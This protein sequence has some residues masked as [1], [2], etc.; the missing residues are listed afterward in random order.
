MGLKS[1][2]ALWMQRAID[3]MA[4]KGWA[5]LALMFFAAVFAGLIE[6][7]YHLSGHIVVVARSMLDWL[8]WVVLCNL[9]SA[10]RL[11]PVLVFSACSILTNTV[12]WM[13]SYWLLPRLLTV[14]VG[15]R[16]PTSDVLVLLAAF[17]LLALIILVFGVVASKRQAADA[18]SL[19]TA[20]ASLVRP[21][22]SEKMAAA[23]KLTSREAE[24]ASL[25][26]QG[27]SMKKVAS[28]LFISMSTAQSHIKSA[29]R[30]LDVHSKD[31]LIDKLSEWQSGSE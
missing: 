25:F 2:E 11:S 22:V 26:A 29:Y 16:L 3:S 4:L 31:E 18:L 23:F 28:L 12:S 24:V 15:G 1:G 21:C 13:L 10:K 8:L 27:H 14:E 17:A 5:A 6:G 9:V 7:S 20:E 19:S 30:K